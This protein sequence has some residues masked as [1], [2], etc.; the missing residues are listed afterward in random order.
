MRKL[1]NLLLFMLLPLITAGCWDYSELE[2]RG[3]V[4]C[5]GIDRAV[6]AEKMKVTVSVIRPGE[7]IT[8]SGQ[9]SAVRASSAYYTATGYT[10]L[11][12]TRNFAMQSSRKLIWEHN[13]NLIIGEVVAREGIFQLIDRF[14]RRPEQRLRT[15]IF[16]AKGTEAKEIVETVTKMEDGL[17]SELEGLIKNSLWISDAPQVDLKFFTE[18]LSSKTAAAVAPRLELIRAG[19]KTDAGDYPGVSGPAGAAQPKLQRLQLTGTAVFKGDRLAGWL[20][21]AESRGLLW[22]LGKVQSG[23]IMVKC[24]GDESSLVS[25]ELKEM[26]SKIKPEKKEGRIRII[27]EVNTKSTLDDV[28]GTADLSTP[29]AVRSLERRQSTVVKNEILAAVDQAHRYGADIFAFGEA[30]NRRYPQEWK[31]MENRWDE[32]FPLLEIELNVKSQIINTG[33]TDKPVRPR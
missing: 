6:E 15:W 22:V 13:R 5:A 1:I 14:T 24:P 2:Q 16:V 9:G 17:G 31:E 28:Q 27:V 21:K 3:I 30:V 25:L 10:I 29:E 33:L 19:E 7:V 4:C 26:H 20:N 23:I 11:D 8:D 12:T 18:R 32:L